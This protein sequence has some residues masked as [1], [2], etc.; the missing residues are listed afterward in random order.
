M[1]SFSI[2]SC[3]AK[4]AGHLH[5]H[6]VWSFVWHLI[7]FV[8]SS[9]SVQNINKVIRFVFFVSFLFVTFIQ[10][11]VC[12]EKLNLTLGEKRIKHEKFLIWMSGGKE[13]LWL[14]WQ[15]K[16]LKDKLPECPKSFFFLYASVL[17][18]LDVIG[19]VCASLFDRNLDF[20]SST[21]HIL[22]HRV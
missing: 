9:V 10:K 22:G 3:F 4:W 16:R 1:E 21:E 5:L 19:C 14:L 11:I 20:L 17:C 7:C 15:T 2:Y 12:L 13:T 6:T 18:S 8:S